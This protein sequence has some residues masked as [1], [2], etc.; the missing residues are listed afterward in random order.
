M[1]LNARRRLGFTHLR[2]QVSPKLANASR[3][4]AATCP[5]GFTLVELL[6]VI[7]IIGMLI[8]LLLP[9]VQRSRETARQLQCLNNIRQ[10]AIATVSYETSKTQLPALSQIVKRSADK[11]VTIIY[12]APSR[13]FGVDEIQTT[14]MTKVAGLSWA[15]MLLPRLERGDIWDQIQ[16]VGTIVPAPSLPV[17]TCPSDTDLLSQP[18]VAGISYSANAGAWD[19]DSSGNFQ[20]KTSTGDTVDNGLFFDAAE[21]ARQNNSPTSPLMRISAIKDGAGTTLLFAENNTKAYT[22]SNATIFSWLGASDR[23]SAEQQFGFN[24]V[25]AYPPQILS[26]ANPSLSSATTT[27]QERIGKVGNVD[28]ND[29]TNVIPFMALRPYFSRPSSPHTSGANVAFCDGHASFMRDDMDY[30]VY[31]ALMTP[32]GSR[33]EDPLNHV[34]SNTGGASLPI[35]TFRQAAPIAEKDI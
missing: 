13:K 16:T 4:D 21:Y 18:D 2:R 30:K 24:W 20:Y 19:R 33:C 29:T 1:A 31:Q 11:Y 27:M 14:D 28:I 34:G 15:A 17:F 3:R 22:N 6:V 23:F 32:R 25:V 5:H 8:A 35:K 26:G 12:D 9:A 7:T 10:L